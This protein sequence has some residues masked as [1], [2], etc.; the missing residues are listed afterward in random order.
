MSEIRGK[1]VTR[2]DGSEAL[3]LSTKDMRRLFKRLKR[4]GYNPRWLVGGG[5]V[6][7]CPCCNE[8][9]GL[10]CLPPKEERPS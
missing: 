3:E 8:V 2:N 5:F 10:T 4:R 6:A 9:D 7:T 1:V